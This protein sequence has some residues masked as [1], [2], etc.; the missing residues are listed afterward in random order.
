MKNIKFDIADI[1]D[2]VGAYNDGMSTY[3]VSKLFG[4]SHENVLRWVAKHSKLRTRKEA[5]VIQSQN[6]KG[7][8]RSPQTQFKRGLTPWNK[9][10]PF[11]QIRGERHPGYGKEAIWIKGVNNPNWKGGVT[12]ANAKARKIPLYKIWREAVMY[13]DNWTCQ[14]CGK[15]GGRLTAHHVTTFSKSEMLRYSLLNGI[16]LCEPCHAKRHPD[17]NYASLVGVN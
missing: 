8:V 15:R 5:D 13:K 7:V 6:L 1:M 12:N 3:S 16:T 9:G 17:L 14:D 4:V 10:K 11:L 2:C